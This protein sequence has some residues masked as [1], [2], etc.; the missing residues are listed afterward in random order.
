MRRGDP[1]ERKTELRRDGDGA[2]RF[3]SKARKPIR[4]R[5][6]KRQ[7]ARP[8]EEALTA[9]VYARDGGCVLRDHA[10]HVCTGPLTPHHRLKASQGGGWSRSNIICL[11]AYGNQ[12]VEDE[13]AA[14]DALGLVTHYYESIN[15]STERMTWLAKVA[16]LRI[17]ADTDEADRCLCWPWAQTPGPGGYG[18]VYFEGRVRSA[19][20]LTMQF[21]GMALPVHPDQTRHLCGNPPCVNPHHL[22]VGSY[23]ENQMDRVGHGTSNAG[24][25]NGRT[26]LSNADARAI[27]EAYMVYA[28]GP[29]MRTNVPQLA[30]EHGVSHETIRRIVNG[31]TFRSS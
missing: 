4:S 5:S 27:R 2:R 8:A 21:A 10:S 18:K 25:R 15:E 26:R 20:H 13:P 29:P 11:C 7:A 14:A 3:A 30:R 22:L 19:H 16:W 31:H 24:E 6:V 28:Q 1:L 23:S 17:A 9:E 12:W